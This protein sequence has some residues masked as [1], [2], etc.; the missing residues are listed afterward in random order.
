M[1]INNN[2]LALGVL[3]KRNIKLYFKDRPLVFFSILA[4]ILVLV[5]YILFLGDLQVDM[6]MGQL[7]NYNLDGVLTVADI[8]AI[9]NNWM[10]AGLV[11][12]SCL[13]V[14]INTNMIMLKD[15]QFGTINDM[16]SSPVKK[17]VVYLSYIISSVLLTLMICFI[18]L[19]LAI[20][21][22]A[23]ANQLF[24]SFADF[25]AI[26]G[27]TLISVIS[28]SFFMALICSFLKSP[29]SLSALN[30]VLGTVLGFLIGAYLPFS[31]M[32]P[33]LQYVSCFIPWTYSVGMFKEYFLRGCI[34][35]LE[36]KLPA[37][38]GIMD[39]LNDNFALSIDFFGTEVTT[40]WMTLILLLSIAVFG[41]LLIVFYSN[42]KT[43]FFA[44]KIKKKK[45]KQKN[46]SK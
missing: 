44:K 29:G 15:K 11:G 43:N 17:W 14:C 12:I 24:L 6:V 26:I 21:Y 36:G 13:T 45:I 4:P 18:V 33:A 10:V 40:S 25:L 3:I 32:P 39:L 22:L 38:S 1:K 28:A 20:I 42:K 34:G 7:E 2:T 46:I 30:S 19:I 5:L 23:C 9:I 37:D 35:F 8:R 31:M 41:I 16:L 27:V